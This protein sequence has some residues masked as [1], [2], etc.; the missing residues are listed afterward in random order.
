M[1]AVETQ[2]CKGDKDMHLLHYTHIRQK[3]DI[4]LTIF[5]GKKMPK[6]STLKSQVNLLLLGGGKTGQLENSHEKDAKAAKV[7]SYLINQKN[8][9]QNHLILQQDE[10]LKK[11]E[12]EEWSYYLLK[13]E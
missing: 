7:Q 13:K 11:L 4:F 3:D 6:Y 10:R 2:N 1:I 8:G 9:D 12:L 5:R